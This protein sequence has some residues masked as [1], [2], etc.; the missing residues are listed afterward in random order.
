M[1]WGDLDVT[2][3]EVFEFW[4]RKADILFC[5][6][7]TICVC[8]PAVLWAVGCGVPRGPRGVKLQKQAPNFEF[9]FFCIF[10]HDF[11][12]SQF[13]QKVHTVTLAP[14]TPQNNFK[15]H[16]GKLLTCNLIVLSGNSK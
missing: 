9:Q 11:W 12:E 8:S 10:P 2:R 16:F 3:P 15:K 6:G 4:A 13:C 1:V 5:F 14:I 7:N